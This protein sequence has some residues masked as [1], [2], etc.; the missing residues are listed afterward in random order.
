MVAALFG[1]WFRVGGT[2][3]A[4]AGPVSVLR[5][6]DLQGVR[7]WAIL[8][9]PLAPVSW[10][11]VLREGQALGQR[12]CVCRVMCACARFCV[13]SSGCGCTCV[14]VWYVSVFLD[15][16]LDRCVGLFA[17]LLSV[18][19][20]F[21]FLCACHFEGVHYLW[22]TCEFLRVCVCVCQSSSTCV[23][24]VC[25]CSFRVLCMTIA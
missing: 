14:L 1:C 5:E 13:C 17:R 11:R 12:V 15:P 24:L 9:P 20:L 23:V 25:V 6:L 4:V 8:A 22:S 18:G 3:S 16:V 21:V 10:G 2:R 19:L 7:G